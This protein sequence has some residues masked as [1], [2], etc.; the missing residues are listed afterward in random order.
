MTPRRALLG[1]ACALL[2]ACGTNVD[3]GGRPPGTDGGSSKTDAAQA[4][5]PG[6]AA[7]GVSAMCQASSTMKLQPNGCYGG[8]Y[9][10]ASDKDCQPRSVAC[11]TGHDG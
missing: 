7:P 8:Y 10:R 11:G 1:S 9:C 6:Y 2:V 3:L 5:C 4:T